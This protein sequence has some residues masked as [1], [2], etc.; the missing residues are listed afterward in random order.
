MI[1]LPV[2]SIFVLSSCGESENGGSNSEE[3]E[4]IEEDLVAD[5]PLFRGDPEMKGVTVETIV[6]P[7]ELAW[8]FEPPVEEGKRRPPIEA[9]PVV[10][11]G[12]IYVGSQSGE[13][14]AIELASGE[15]KWTFEAEGPIS[16]PGA[17]FDGTVFL[18]DTYGFVY[19]LNGETG[20]ELWRFESE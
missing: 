20:E 11:D 19:A 18:G 4:V 5:W 1:F 6:P 7:L 13:F 14:Y 17:A 10:I 8:T 3:S 2:V 15:L 16:A 9:S 12:I